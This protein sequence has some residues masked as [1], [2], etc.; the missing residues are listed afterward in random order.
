MSGST[1]NGVLRAAWALFGE[2]E[3][4]GVIYQNPAARVGRFAENSCK[5]GTLSQ[6]ELDRLFAL[7]ALTNTWKGRRV[8]YL[9]A[10]V[11]VGCGLWHG[12]AVA[13]RPSDF[14]GGGGCL[15]ALAAVVRRQVVVEIL[16]QAHEYVGRF[17]FMDGHFIV[18]RATAC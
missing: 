11:A 9:I 17:S 3:R 16:K 14:T 8:P 6:D 1:V 15:Y 12:E 5:R 10:M 2:A 7:D 18:M 4:L 13:L